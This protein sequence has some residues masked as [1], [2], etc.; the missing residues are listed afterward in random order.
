MVAGR[1]APRYQKMAL[2]YSR[3]KTLQSNLS[4][5]FIVVV[6]LCHHLLNITKKSVFGQLL[7][8]L[9]DSE[10]KDYESELLR[11]ASAVKE[12]ANLMLN[13]SMN[14][15]GAGVRMLLKISESEAYRQKLRAHCQLLDSCSTYDYETTWKE[16]RKAGNVT[17]LNSTPEYK[18]WRSEGDSSTLLWK[19]KLGAGKS[20]L[21]ANI[22]DDLNLHV[23]DSHVPVTYFFCRHDVSESLMARTVIGSL[24][25]QLLRSIVL[26]TGQAVTDFTIPNIDC[27][28]ILDMLCK[29]LPPTFRAYFV[30]DGLDECDEKERLPIIQHVQMIQQMFGLLVCLSFRVEAGTTPWLVP[31]MFAIPITI[32]IPEENPDIA[33]FISSQ[34]ERSIESA[35]LRVGDPAIILEIEDALLRGSQGMFLWV[36]LQIESLYTSRTDSAI[37]QALADLPKDLPETFSRIIQR[38]GKLGEEYQIRIFKLVVASYRPLSVEELREALSVAPGDATWNPARILNDIYSALACCGS[39]ITINE[40]ALTIKV[41]HHSVKQFLLGGSVS[42]PS[43]LFTA[44]SANQAMG[45]T[46]VTYLNYGVF[47]T[48]LSRMVIPNIVPEA[49]PSRIVKS[50]DTSP[51]VQALALKYLRSRRQPGY[52]MGI[53]LAEAAQKHQPGPKEQFYFYSY[54]NDRWLDHVMFIPTEEQTLHSLVAKL[55]TSHPSPNYIG[56]G[57]DGKQDLLCW[58]AKVG[59]EEAVMALMDT[60]AN[61]EVR[62]VSDMTPL[63]SA[64]WGGHSNVVDILIDKGLSLQSE[65]RTDPIPLILAVLRGDCSI[66]SLLIRRGANPNAA[67]SPAGIYEI[68]LKSPK[69][70]A[71][72]KGVIESLWTR[73]GLQDGADYSHHNIPLV[74]A[75]AARDLSMVKLLLGHWAD[76]NSTRRYPNELDALEYAIISRHL[77]IVEFI[78]FN[79]RGEIRQSHLLAAIR[80]HDVAIVRTLLLENA[81]AV[82]NEVVVEIKDQRTDASEPIFLAIEQERD[83][84]LRLLLETGHRVRRDDM[85]LRTP[86]LAAIENGNA[87]IIKNLLEFWQDPDMGHE[88]AEIAERGSPTFLQWVLEKGARLNFPIDRDRATLAFAITVRCQKGVQLLVKEGADVNYLD[89]HLCRTPLS[90]AL[91]R[92]DMMTIKSIVKANLFDYTRNDTPDK[93]GRTPLSYAVQGGKI[94][95]VSRLLDSGAKPNSEDGKCRTPLSYAATASFP[96]IVKMLLSRGAYINLEAPNGSPL[97]GAIMAGS[98]ESVRVLLEHGADPWVKDIK[99]GCLPLIIARNECKYKIS[100]MISQLMKEDPTRWS[101]YLRNCEHHLF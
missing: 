65:P 100:V 35:K 20:V 73:Y 2:L 43:G 83:D 22:V 57:P 80:N 25:R 60:G 28:R 52:N 47:G 48:S 5:Y 29:T 70:S 86:L 3:S 91:E 95:I 97:V 21:L 96:R 92:G 77:A 79:E 76:S 98:M 9:S 59:C 1:S 74:L 54:A 45:E 44:D 82:K 75:I 68:V 15:Q 81:V 17:L 64:V 42:F 49:S 6:R 66:A 67:A 71:E 50:M 8:F 53:T 26:I 27:E 78:L 94:G 46:I 23:P 89:K 85:P 88:V 39:L 41:I 62:D 14:D 58:A 10:I 101:S 13:E 24:A 37:R 19:G 87:N 33:C 56:H 4:E 40:E 7:S 38:S 18:R 12:E 93:Y 63:Y 84:I 99:T 72:F 36:A 34:L 16:I 69:S 61:V 11:W 30:L 51:S 32:T 31:S 90:Y 55:I